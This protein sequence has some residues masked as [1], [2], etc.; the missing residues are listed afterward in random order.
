MIQYIFR[1]LRSAL[2][3]VFGVCTLTFLLIHL[4]PGDPVDIIL[5][6]QASSFDKEALRRD[7]QLDQPLLT[8]YT[9]FLSRLLRLDLGTSLH[10]RKSV[11][12]QIFQRFPATIELTIAAMILAL[13]VGIPL[14]VSAAVRRH[15]W[16]DLMVNIFSLLSMSTPGIFLG[17]LLIWI[18]S[19]QLDWLPVS[20][21]GG[22]NHL[23]LPAL[24][25]AIPICA[26]IC[27][28][29][30]TSMLEVV[31]EDYIR[32]AKAKGLTPLYIYGKHALANALMPLI[33]IVGLQ[34]G[35]LLTGTLITETIFDW[36]GIGS[37]LIQAIQ[38]R[39]YPLVQACVLL[40]AVIYVSV[41]VLTDVSYA[42]A[43][44][45]VRLS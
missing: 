32:V 2:P 7:L 3:V 12:Q 30:Q 40:I 9:N 21:R 6:E 34:I 45:K 19:L 17:P 5:G 36:P 16:P 18:F 43:N 38:S 31:K 29:T 1:R 37:L 8:Q 24:S 39:D 28:V 14:G 15:Q 35:A 4:V 44:P 42:I 26:V 11:S 23:I 22:L 27:R 10:S 25:L 33:T 41:N 13:S 20:E